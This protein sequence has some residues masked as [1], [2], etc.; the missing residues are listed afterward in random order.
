MKTLFLVFSH[1][2]TNEQIKDAKT[3]LKVDNFVYLPEKLQKIWSNISPSENLNLFEI[4]SWLKQK[5]TQND[6]VLIQG[7]FGATFY[8]VDFCLTNNITPI[9]ATNKRVSKEILK[10][11]GTIEKISIFKHISF[12]KYKKWEKQNDKI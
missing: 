12:R 10:P 3:S 1:N 4:V 7:E 11:D 5:A 8:L 6:F 9:Y 2:L